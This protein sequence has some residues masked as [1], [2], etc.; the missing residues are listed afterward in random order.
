MSQLQG[1]IEQDLHCVIDSGVLNFSMVY[2][3]GP[4]VFT[5]LAYQG[6]GDPNGFG[7]HFR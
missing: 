4:V 1:T 5:H 6:R 2:W 3:T 7:V